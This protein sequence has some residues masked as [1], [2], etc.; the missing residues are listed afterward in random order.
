M[1]NEMKVWMKEVTGTLKALK[2]GQEFIAAKVDSI[3]KRLTNVEED[4]VG[5]KERLDR[6]EQGQSRHEELLKELSI[7]FIENR[8]EIREIKRA[9]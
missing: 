4:V 6:I 9:K 7:G 3:D 8:A 1:D 2:T 5:I